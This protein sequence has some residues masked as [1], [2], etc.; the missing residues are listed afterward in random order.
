MGTKLSLFREPD[1][2]AVYE[3]WSCG[4]TVEGED[5]TCPY[6]TTSRIVCYELT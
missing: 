2:E 3:C 5:A 6:C 1:I 4:T